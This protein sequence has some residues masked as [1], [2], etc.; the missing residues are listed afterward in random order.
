MEKARKVSVICRDEMV[1]SDRGRKNDG[2]WVMSSRYIGRYTQL[3][4]WKEGRREDVDLLTTNS[5]FPLSFPLIKA[6][7]SFPFYPYPHPLPIRT[8]ST[9]HPI[10]CLP[11][12]PL[13]SPPHP[14]QPSRPP[15]PPYNLLIMRETPRIIAP[16]PGY[17]QKNF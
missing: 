2:R 12:S 8:P 11:I 17:Q 7:L 3:L 15:Q 13:T 4:Y 14:T 10:P 16:T 6:H 5:N 1:R 9:P